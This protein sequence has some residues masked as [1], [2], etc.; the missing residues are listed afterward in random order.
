MKKFKEYLKEAAPTNSGGNPQAYSNAA[1]VEGH[2]RITGVLTVGQSSIT[3][4]GSNNKVQVGTGITLD[5]TSGQIQA[6][7]LKIT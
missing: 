2:G 7:E 4:D 6:P 5:A 3:I 1:D